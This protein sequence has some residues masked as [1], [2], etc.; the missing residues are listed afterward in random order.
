[1]WSQKA[2]DFWGSPKTD[3]QKRTANAVPVLRYGG[4]SGIWTLGTEFTAHMISN[5]F[6]QFLYISRQ[7]ATYRH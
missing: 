3:K 5:Q 7:Y 2:Y 4:E 1:M 6:R